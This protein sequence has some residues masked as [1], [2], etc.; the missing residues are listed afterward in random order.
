MPD[1]VPYVFVHHTAMSTCH[2]KEECIA[3][4]Q[5]IQDLHMDTNGWSD[6]G[7]SFL[8]GDDG[9]I[10]EARGFNVV[11]AH[12]RGYNDVG[13]GISFMGN[14]TSA[15]PTEESRSN[16]FALVENCLL[17]GDKIGQNYKLYGHRQPGPVS[18][19]K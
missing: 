12:T 16:Y 17:E 13:Y 6:I 15:L 14:F 2:S 9:R 1:A 10:Y 19:Y 5:E 11:G 7:Y 3:E 18:C 8:L 4:M